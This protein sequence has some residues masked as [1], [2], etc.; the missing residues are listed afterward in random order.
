MH[1]DEARLGCKYPEQDA[2]FCQVTGKFES[3]FLKVVLVQ[4]R[5]KEALEESSS[6]T[7]AAGKTSYCLV[8][9]NLASMFFAIIA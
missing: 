6:V 8:Q 3:V 7:S 5:I 1:A 4:A 9:Q 2:S